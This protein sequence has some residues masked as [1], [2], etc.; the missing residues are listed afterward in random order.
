MAD[1]IQIAGVTGPSEDELEVSR[2]YSDKLQSMGRTLLSG[3]YMLVRSV[4][5]Y[6]PDNAVF[7]KPLLQLQETLNQ[8]IGK[9]GR[10]ELMAVKDS[11]YLNGMLI[12]VELSALENQT[13]L[14]NELRGRDIGG[15]TLFKAITGEELKNFIWIFSKEQQQQP[16]EEDG[17]A[18]RKLVAMKLARFS[19]LREKLNREADGAGD[20]KVDRKKYAMTVYARALF[21]LRKYLDAAQ[22]GKPIDGSGAVRIVQ[23]LVD[24]SYEHRSHFLG[25]TSM[26][27]EREYLAHHMVNVC[28]MSIIFGAELGLTRP[29]LRELGLIALFH[30]SGMISLPDALRAKKGALTAEEKAAMQ[31]VPLVTVRNILAERGF[32]R[33]RLMR[34]VTTFEHKIDYGTAVRDERGNIQEVLPKSTLGVYARILA[35][36]D[37]FDAL[38]SRRPFRDPYGPDVALLLMWTEMR[39]RFDPALLEVFMKVMAI[40]PLKILSRRKRNLTLSG[41]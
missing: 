22:A 37:T 13:Y 30:D 27:D 12:K 39:H 8:L 2:E 4:K 32:S 15:I 16:L 31:K 29:Q 18:G 17:I 21:F 14:L 10:V 6:D 11:L 33:A 34:V 3:L 40:Q 9:D 35:I 23:D 1:S 20:Q 36:C 41:A 19:K 5:M 26:K 7:Q 38:T 25:M 24:I 28:L